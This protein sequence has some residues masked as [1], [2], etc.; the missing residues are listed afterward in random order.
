MTVSATRQVA[1]AVAAVVTLLLAGC[2]RMD[3]DG[4]ST[5]S[6][7]SAYL[8]E[9]T[10]ARVKAYRDAQSDP[11]QPSAKRKPDYDE[12]LAHLDTLAVGEGPRARIPQFPLLANDNLVL[13]E[14]LMIRLSDFRSVPPRT[15]RP[16]DTRCTGTISIGSRI[17]PDR[18]YVYAIE[19][20]GS[21]HATQHRGW[22]SL[23]LRMDAATEERLVDTIV[24]Q[25]NS[26]WDAQAGT[27]KRP[28]Q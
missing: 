21:F 13:R 15:E 24:T 19:F 11:R 16:R 7:V 14:T 26:A 27:F 20:E 17:H 2:N 25:L 9:Q 8:Y 22:K 10:G 4:Q 3:C 28:P 5:A 6:D 18:V 12:L 1:V 23:Q